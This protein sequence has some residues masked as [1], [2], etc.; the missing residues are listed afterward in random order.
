MAYDFYVIEGKKLIDYKPTAEHYERAIEKMLKNDL[1]FKSDRDKMIKFIFLSVKKI[2]KE[3][4]CDNEYTYE[5]AQ[6][7]L[8]FMF[9]LTDLMATLTP[10]EF[11]R[12]FPISKEYDGEKFGFKDYFSTIEEVMKYPLNMPIGKQ[13]TEFLMEYYNWDIVAFE[14][15]KLTTISI[16]RRFE[17]QKGVFEEFAEQNGLHLHTFYKDEDEVVDSDTGERFKIIR[18][19]NKLQR[20]FKVIV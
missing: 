8:E 17:G 9:V 15:S 6:A 14:V 13:I 19:K 18:P 16:I 11:M 12:L 3:R 10:V 4:H 7:R 5:Q 20:L 1:S 2:V